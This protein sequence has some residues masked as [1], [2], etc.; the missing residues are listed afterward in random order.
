M[1]L[2]LPGFIM[3]KKAAE[4][5]ALIPRFSL[6]NTLFYDIKSIQLG[7]RPRAR[8]QILDLLIGV[9]ILSPQP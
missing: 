4:L 3:V 5:G 7:S 2:K 9:R 8:R 1:K 6:Q